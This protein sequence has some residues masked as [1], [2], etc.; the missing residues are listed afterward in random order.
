MKLLVDVMVIDDERVVSRRSA[1]LRWRLG[2][3]RCSGHED[4]ELAGIRWRDTGDWLFRN[5]FGCFSLIGRCVD[6]W[7]WLRVKVVASGESSGFAVGAWGWRLDVMLVRRSFGGWRL[8]DWI[9]R[10]DG[11]QSGRLGGCLIADLGLVVCV[12]V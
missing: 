10:L 3:T 12:V 11:I 8:R 9:K 5:V 4:C 2:V 1:H 7:W 6:P